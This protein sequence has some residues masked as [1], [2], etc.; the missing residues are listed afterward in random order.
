MDLYSIWLHINTNMLYIGFLFSWD[1]FYLIQCNWLRWQYS[2]SHFSPC[3][4]L[5]GVDHLIIFETNWNF[6][7]LFERAHAGN[8]SSL[9]RSRARPSKCFLPSRNGFFPGPISDRPSRNRERRTAVDQKN[10]R[11]AVSNLH[12]LPLPLRSNT[13]VLDRT[14]ILAGCNKFHC[15]V[16]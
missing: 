9:C 1:N 11:G 6:L 3:P 14:T 16:K 15:L 13:D 5:I 8:A 4:S 2:F 10:C 7:S 12:P